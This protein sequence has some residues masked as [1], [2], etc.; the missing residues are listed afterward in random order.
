MPARR[1]T[2][3]RYSHRLV[4]E[5]ST[6]WIVLLGFLLCGLV[7]A[8]LGGR[9]NALFGAEINIATQS[10]VYGAIAVYFATRAV[11]DVG[12]GDTVEAT[13][14]GLIALSMF[15]LAGLRAGALWVALTGRIPED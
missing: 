4:G 11:E 12:R 3:R 6:F 15:L 1:T 7:L 9:T 13:V 8:W 5:V 14:N 2:R 10:L